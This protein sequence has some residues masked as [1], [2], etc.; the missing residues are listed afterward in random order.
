MPWGRQKG[1][2]LGRGGSE[3]PVSCGCRM[4][5]QT[6]SCLIDNARKGPSERAGNETSNREMGSS[7]ILSSPAWCSTALARHE[8]M[9]SQAAAGSLSPLAQALVKVPPL[10]PPFWEH[11][12]CW[13]P[14][15]EGS[16][17][18]AIAAAAATCTQQLPSFPGGEACDRG[19]SQEGSFPLGSVPRVPGRG[20]VLRGDVAAPAMG[21]D[22]KTSPCPGEQLRA[23]TTAH[24][25]GAE[26]IGALAQGAGGLAGL[27]SNSAMWSEGFPRR[28]V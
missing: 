10:Q 9:R 4:E 1:E 14:S 22:G 23:P 12:Q 24:C 7:A 3:W 13:E 16:S 18:A 6:D 27:A 19:Y 5:T 8:C 20:A 21:P 11:R 17:S 28:A 26:E 2:V 15:P 25:L